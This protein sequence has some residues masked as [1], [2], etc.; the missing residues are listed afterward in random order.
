MQ[1]LLIVGV[2]WHKIASKQWTPNVAL[3]C[4]GW[5]GG[6]VADKL[7]VIRGLLISVFCRNT[8]KEVLYIVQMREMIFVDS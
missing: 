7:I 6:A 8:L 1:V 4:K 3:F 2:A 5:L